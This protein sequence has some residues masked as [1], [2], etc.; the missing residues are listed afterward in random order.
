[1]SFE[2]DRHG[3]LVRQQWRAIN[4]ELVR[5]PRQEYRADGSRLLIVRY[6]DAQGR[7]ASPAG[8][9]TARAG[10]VAQQLLYDEPGLH[11]GVLQLG[12]D[13]K[14]LPAQPS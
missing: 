9:P 2:Y 5:E 3:N 1:M 12:A 13:M 10:M 14:P 11:N 7:P 8:L 4:V 6:F